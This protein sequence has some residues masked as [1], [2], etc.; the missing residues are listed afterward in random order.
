[1]PISPI[2]TPQKKL[3]GRGEELTAAYFR[4]QG[5]KIIA[6]N[7]RLGRR[8]IDLIARRKNQLVFIEVKTRR[9]TKDSGWENPLGR[10]QT[11]RLR[12]ALAAY[13]AGRHINPETVRLDLVLI[14]VREKERLAQLRHY[15]G[16]L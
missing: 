15:P 3:G 12:L 11:G 6:R 9:L 13:C 1:M 7:F 10:R 5:Y 14:L 8:E 16:I 4:R 2:L